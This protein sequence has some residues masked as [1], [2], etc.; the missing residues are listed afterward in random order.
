M[1]VNGVHNKIRE[2]IDRASDGVNMACYSQGMLDFSFMYM[3][4]SI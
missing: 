4:S 3:H 1:Q 2:F